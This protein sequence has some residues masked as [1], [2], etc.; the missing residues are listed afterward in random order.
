M[1][2]PMPFRS[3]KA[4][5]SQPSNVYRRATAS[6]GSGVIEAENHCG[7]KARCGLCRY[8]NLDYKSGLEEKHKAGLSILESTGVLSGARI[9]PPTPSPKPY[10]YRSLFKL[11][12]RPAPARAYRG[13]SAVQGE[14]PRFAI[15][16]FEQ[17]SHAVIDMDRCPL[18]APSLARLIPDLRHELENSPLSPYNEATHT[19]Q[20]RYIVARTAHLTGELMVTFVVTEA[21]RA[22]LKTLVTNLQRLGHR[23]N[24]V[25]M[26]IHSEPGN[27]IFGSETVRIAGADR[28]RERV[29]DLDFEVGPTSF[30]Q[31]NPW[32]AMTL[33]RRVEQI[34]G[35]AAPLAVA[36]D[37]YCGIGQMSLILGRL[38]YKVLGIEENEKATADAADNAR[39][40]R[41][42][43]KTQFVASR[44][45]DA[46]KMIPV[47]ASSPELIVV[48]PSRRGLAEAT[49]E[50]LSALLS[51][52]PKTRFVY[53]SCSAESLARDLKALT[54]ATGFHVRQIEAFDMFAQTD[55]LEWLAVLTH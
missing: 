34:A 35:P 23:I 8:V 40:N 54:E 46:G 16:L 24:S 48:N 13:H 5:V 14:E 22:E 32:Q 33:Y 20:L 29:L 7:I 25:H 47:W 26:N 52:R 51:A 28:L 21:L 45:E 27:A 15:G 37:L 38:G 41:L 50:E 19:G 31:I 3:P 17:G 43:N 18:H 10:G 44:V 11:A 2:R 39:R 42:E 53:V 30:F 49:R 55:G 4:R 6:Q 1:K 9:L 36:W 12:V